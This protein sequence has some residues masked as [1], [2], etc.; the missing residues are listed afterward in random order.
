[1]A[2]LEEN[3]TVQDMHE[4]FNNYFAASMR[5]SY[6]GYVISGSLICL[7]QKRQHLNAL[8]VNNDSLP[9]EHLNT[10]LAIV[11]VS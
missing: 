9:G 4:L 6:R 1:M 11:F 8:L 3:K 10:A 5:V 7:L 2:V